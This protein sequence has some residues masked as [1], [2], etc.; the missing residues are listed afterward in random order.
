[1]LF[2]SDKSLIERLPTDLVEEIA[3]Y[4]SR[5]YPRLIEVVEDFNKRNVDVGVCI[6]EIPDDTDFYIVQKY[7]GT[8]YIKSEDD[9]KEWHC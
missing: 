4:E 9:G 3:K 6:V 8:E 7:I 2:R 1:M 5:N